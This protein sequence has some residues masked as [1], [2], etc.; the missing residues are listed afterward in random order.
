MFSNKP[1]HQNPHFVYKENSKKIFKIVQKLAGDLFA[2]EARGHLYGQFLK[3]EK[4]LCGWKI[5]AW[6]EIKLNYSFNEWK[7][8][9]A[10]DRG[11]W[12]KKVKEAALKS[13]IINR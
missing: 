2:I 5:N 12:I 3:Q 7:R 11:V 6:F 1:F 13:K 10:D 8:S 9:A 4:W